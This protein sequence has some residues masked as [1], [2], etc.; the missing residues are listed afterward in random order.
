MTCCPNHRL[1]TESVS[2]GI[3]EA[4][5]LN[6]INHSRSLKQCRGRSRIVNHKIVYKIQYIRS[7]RDIKWVHQVFKVKKI[8]AMNTEL[9]EEAIKN[10]FYNNGADND[11]HYGFATIIK[12]VVISNQQVGNEDIY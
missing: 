8:I 4:I 6:E 9:L 1:S 3:Q 12:I 5:S 2:L 7:N 11:E 10:N